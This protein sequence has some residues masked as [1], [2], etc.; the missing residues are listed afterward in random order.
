MAKYRKNKDED[1]PECPAH[2]LGRHT[3]WP[4]PAYVRATY[5]CDYYGKEKPGYIVSSDF[6]PG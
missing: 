1:P 4:H 2:Y 3:D 6:W 5:V